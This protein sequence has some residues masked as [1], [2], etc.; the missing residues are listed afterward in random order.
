MSCMIPLS[1]PDPWSA[2]KG[3]GNLVAVAARALT[4]AA[5]QPVERAVTWAS[6]A[7]VEQQPMAARPNCLTIVQLDISIDPNSWVMR[8]CT[9]VPCIL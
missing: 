2:P 6:L 5:D 3:K 1:A 7:G 9:A 4:P 8:N